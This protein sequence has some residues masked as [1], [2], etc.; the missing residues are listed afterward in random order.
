MTWSS[1]ATTVLADL[2]DPDQGVAPGLALPAT[3]AGHRVDADAHADMVF[4]LGLLHEAG[5]ERIGDLDV[6]ALLHGPP[7]GHRRRPHPHVLLLPH[8]RDRRRGS[9]AS[10][11]STRRPATWSSAAATA[12]SG[13]RCS[14]RASFPATT[15]VVLARCELARAALGLDVGRGGARRPGRAG[16]RPLRRAPRGLARRLAHRA[17][18]GRHVHGRRLPVRRAVRRP[19]GPGV[20]PGPGARPPAWSPRSPPPAARRC[21]GAARSARWRCATAPSWRPLLL[22]RSQPARRARRDGPTPRGGGRWPGPRRPGPP[23][24][25]TGGLVGGPQ[26]AGAVP[27]PG[28]VPTPA[29]DARLPGQAG[30]RRARPPAGRRRARTPAGG[31][32]P[33]SRRAT[34]GWG[35]ATASACGPAATRGSL[36][37]AGRRR[38]RRRLRARAPPPDELD[39]PTDQPLA[40]FVPLAWRGETRFAPGGRAAA[41]VHEAGALDLVHDG[42]WSTSRPAGRG[43]RHPGRPAAGPLPGRRPHADGRRGPVLPR[44]AARRAGGAGPRDCRASR[45]TSRPRAPPVT[46]VTTV[47]VDGLAEWRVGQRRAARRPPG[48]AGPGPGRPL[49]VDGHAQ[50]AGRV[51]RPTTTAVPPVPVRPARRPGRRPARAI[52]P[53]RRP[54]RLAAALAGADVVHLHWPEWLT[55]PSTAPGGT[56]RRRRGRHRGARGVDPAQ[57]RPPRRPDGRRAVPPVGGAGRR[58]DP[59]QRVGPRGR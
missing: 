16:G 10:T 55:G 45:C 40:C 3:L 42:F 54:D 13:S 26:A 8:R 50:A 2:A 12:R 44:A 4:T 23:A 5:V 29:D 58:R 6:E 37:P 21:R 51:H 38:T 53:A 30:R 41:V 11:P 43:R 52:P 9:A 14:T 32:P 31:R 57:P 20:G 27:L 36:R 48:R 7:G 1:L 18:P 24:G 19:P 39:V 47:D 28:P 59:P 35:S 17:G 33:P 22:R 56:G 25:S 49:P 46:R 34:P 15:R